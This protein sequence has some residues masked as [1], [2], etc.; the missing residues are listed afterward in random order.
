MSDDPCPSLRCR[1]L[2]RHATGF[3]IDVAFTTKRAVTALVGPSGSGKTTVL[4]LIAGL[5]TPLAG[6]IT[7]G[8]DVLVD[9]AEGQRMP[10]ESRRVGVLFQDNALFP[11]LTVRNNIRFGAARRETDQALVDDVIDFC[12]VGNLLDRWPNQLSGG[13]A[14]RTALA[15][16]LL[17]RPRLLLLDE[18]LTSVEASLRDQ[19]VVSLIER[20][21][22]WNIP[23]V[24]VTHSDSLVRRFADDIFEMAHGRLAIVENDE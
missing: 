6:R 12:E 24:L 22:Q 11:H 2:Y 3:E 17:C 5:R 4:E 19:I 9:T 13:Q 7:I 15:R 8:S 16:A 23:L 1:V 20:I 14:Q 21:R 10:M 18:P